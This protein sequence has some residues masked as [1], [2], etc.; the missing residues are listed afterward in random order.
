MQVQAF[1]VCIRKVSVIEIYW[2][3]RAIGGKKEISHDMA[4]L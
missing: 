2:H 4:R 3:T 1:V